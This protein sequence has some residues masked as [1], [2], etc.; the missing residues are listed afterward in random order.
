MEQGN[1]RWQEITEQCDM[2]RPLQSIRTISRLAE[3]F[4]RAWPQITRCSRPTFTHRGMYR[5][6]A[7]VRS[8]VTLSAVLDASSR[9]LT[10]DCSSGLCLGNVRDTGT[11]RM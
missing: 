6:I 2:Y 4:D 10:R 9:A 3:T 8:P 1:G 7:S 5:A 11:T